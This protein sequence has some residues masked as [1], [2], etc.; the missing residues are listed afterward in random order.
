M[1]TYKYS[2]DFTFSGKD[3]HNNLSSN[4]ELFKKPAE[5]CKPQQSEAL[6]LLGQIKEILS[7]DEL[8]FLPHDIIVCDENETLFSIP[9][10]KSFL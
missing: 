6:F 7:Q 5:G 3:Y 2:I 1:D 10:L 4:Q 9:D 8:P